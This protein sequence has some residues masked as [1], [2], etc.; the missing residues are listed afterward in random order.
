MAKLGNM[1]VGSIVKLNVSGVATNFIVVHQG[2]PSTMYDDSCDGTWL[3]MEDILKKVTWYQGSSPKNDYETSYMRSYLEGTVLGLFDS[4]IR[5]LIKQVKIPYTKGESKTGAVGTL[6]T[7]ANGLSTKIFILSRVEV[8]ASTAANKEG[9]KLSYFA[10][11][12]ASKRIAKLSGSATDW[13]TRSPNVAYSYATNV[14]RITSTGSCGAMSSSSSF[15]C[16]PAIIMPSECGVDSS[17]FVLPSSGI[18]GSVNIGGTW[19]ELSAVHVNVGGVWKEVSVG[20]V[21]IGGVWK[22]IS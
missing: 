7:G 22:P 19:K 16:R 2:K 1:A 3:L 11:E 13:W 18:N 12:T 14:Y 20:Y 9:D 17:G 5:E 8:G 21:N 15:G 4:D 10:D 6:Q